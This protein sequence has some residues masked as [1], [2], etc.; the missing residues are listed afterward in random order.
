MK[1]ILLCSVLTKPYFSGSGINMFYFAK[2]LLKL[3]NHVRILSFSWNFR[4]PLL[5]TLDGIKILRVPACTIKGINFLLVLLSMPFILLY[6]MRFE[7]IIIYGPFIPQFMLVARFA[8]FFGVKTVFQSVN[9]TMDDADAMLN[10]S[11]IGNK[12][13]NRTL[14]G[15]SLY[16]AINK[17]F[18]EKYSSKF[19]GCNNKVFLSSQGVDIARF[20][21]A[22]YQKIIDLKTRYSIS[23]DQKIILSIGNLINR[24]GYGDIF[25]VLSKLPVDYLYIVVGNFTS[26]KY[27]YWQSSNQMLDLYRK[28]KEMLGDRIWFLGAIDNV[29]EIISIADVLLMNSEREGLPN[30]LLEAMAS[31]LPCVFRSLD[32]VDDML[33]VN[34]H[35]YISFNDN[36]GM[37]SGLMDI[38]L[39]PELS[40]KIAENAYQAIIENHSDLLV[41][42]RLLDRL[43][44]VK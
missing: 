6:T 8:N 10:K 35:H 31:R 42:E 27:F 15:I 39:K 28:G 9:L 3:N 11:L 43:S 36:R 14:K 22:N 4:N 30:C 40:R 16:H 26:N 21:P 2:T 5:E 29:E 19:P 20:K 37:Y 24:K 38:L 13:N 32:G 33:G 7:I 41:A 17:T 12:I 44:D 18:A 23:I 34:G 1:K 25:E